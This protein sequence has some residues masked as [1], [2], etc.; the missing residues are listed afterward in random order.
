MP[1]YAVLAVQTRELTIINMWA[2]QLASEGLNLVLKRIFKEERPPEG[3][4]HLNGYGFP[5]SHSQFM[6]YFG[7][8]LICHMYFRHRF[9]STRNPFVDQAF[10]SFVYL[11]ITTWVAL[12]AYSRL[13][14]LYHTPHQV[15]WGLGIGVG[16]GTVHYIFT[17]LIPYRWPLSIFG[18]VRT[19][20]LAHPVVGWM[21]IR[22]G[23]AVWPDGGRE[24]EWKR[25]KDKYDER[26]A[27]F[28]QKRIN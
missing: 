9:A 17:E 12:V 1:A 20:V 7:A 24:G 8:F 23:W 4:L 15:A 21:Q 5:S 10:R 27:S 13:N 16:L 28:H 14:L 26:Q 11:A 18:R 3:K 2:G 6:G 22:D 19:T 25:W